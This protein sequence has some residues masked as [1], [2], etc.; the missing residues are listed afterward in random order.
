MTMT[1]WLTPLDVGS[2]DNVEE[3]PWIQQR[4]YPKDCK[5]SKEENL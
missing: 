5:E 1:G 3:R 2:Y 4:W